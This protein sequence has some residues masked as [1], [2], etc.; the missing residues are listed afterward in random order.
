MVKNSG[1]SKAKS[2]AR[3]NFVDSSPLRFILSPD[4]RYAVVLKLFG[5]S[6]CQVLSHDNITYNAIIRGKLRGKSKRSN[7]I[8]VSSLVI[9]SIRDFSNNISDIVHVYSTAHFNVFKLLPSF[10]SHLFP[11]INNHDDFLFS[12]DNE[13][14]QS[15]DDQS[16]H[17]NDQPIST[18]N[19][20]FDFHDI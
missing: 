4:E 11:S 19:N 20:N 2:F 18:D 17:N 8:S 1:G 15:I 14:I 7:F 13:L 6:I 5:G 10:P 9:I 3:K 12:D 16:I